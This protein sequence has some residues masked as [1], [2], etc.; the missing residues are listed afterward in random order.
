MSRGSLAA[1]AVL[2]V[3]V[4]LLVVAGAYGIELDGDGSAGPSPLL[5][6]PAPDIA[7]SLLDGT[8]EIAAGEFRGDILVLHFWS[9]ACP[10]CVAVR[11]AL[12]DLAVA[13][14]AF[15]VTVVTVLVQ[16]TPA[17]GRT[18]LGENGR[19][20]LV[21][22]AFDPDSEVALAYG[23]GPVPATYFIDRAGTVAG[24]VAGAAGF[25]LMGATIDTII[26][27]P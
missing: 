10:A 21:S 25:D 3:A 16:G 7:I 22:D 17:A 15:G 1:G 26:V 14:E 23:V 8:G 18:F 20:P 19:S 11:T 27:G 4:V 2:A 5:D 13:Y 6:G 12:L 24:K 9:P